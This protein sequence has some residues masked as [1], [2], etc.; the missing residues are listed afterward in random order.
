M[1]TATRC[2][3]VLNGEPIET[4]ARTLEDVVVEAGFG[5][6][7]VATAVNGTFVAAGQRAGVMITAGDKV[8]VVSAR[9]GG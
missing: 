3:I 1:N 5:E 8:E 4:G 6:A 9:Q 7:R 2:S